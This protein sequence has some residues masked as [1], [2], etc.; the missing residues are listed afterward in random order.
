MIE[1]RIDL[2]QDTVRVE[3]YYQQIDTLILA[4]DLI[5]VLSG[6]LAAA[7]AEEKKE[8]HK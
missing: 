6:N 4:L 8:T 1:I 5:R 3:G 2:Y 7:L